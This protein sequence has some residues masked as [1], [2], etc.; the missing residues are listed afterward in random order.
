MNDPGLKAKRILFIVNPISGGRKKNLI[1]QAIEKRLGNSG[2]EYRIAETERPGHASDLSREAI[3]G[4]T[5]VI[6]AVGGD[7]TINETASAMINTDTSLGIIP[8]GSGNGLARH[9]KIPFNLQ[10]ALD[11]ILAGKVITIDTGTLDD[12]VFL[13]IAGVGYDAF[14]AR[15]FADAGEKGISYL[16]Q[17]DYKGIPEL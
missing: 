7:G 4:N 8:T 3:A 16:S 5:D 10:K 2:I 15:K 17:S 12:Q 11:T 9:L 13:N 14:I 6:V 1:I